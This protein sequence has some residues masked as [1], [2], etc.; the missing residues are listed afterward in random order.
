[1]LFSPIDSMTVSADR[2]ATPQTILVVVQM[3]SSP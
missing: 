1:M 3:G 2:R